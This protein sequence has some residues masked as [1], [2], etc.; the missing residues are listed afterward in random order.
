[1]RSWH[2]ALT[3]KATIIKLHIIFFFYLYLKVSLEIQVP[4]KVQQHG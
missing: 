1:M 3:K 2:H 4:L